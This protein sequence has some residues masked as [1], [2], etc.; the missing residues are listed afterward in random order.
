MYAR[1]I[2]RVVDI[3]L[4][5]IAAVLL[6][7]PMV[8]IGIIIKIDDPKGKVIFKQ[9]RIGRNGKRFK[10]LK[11]RT[12]RSDTPKHLPNNCMTPEEYDEYTTKIGKWL[13]KTS[14]DELPQIYNII[15]GDM[16]WVGPRPVI[17]KEV[18][19]LNARRS[20]GL[21]P[22]RPGLTGWAQINGR[23]KLTDE[24]KADFDAQYVGKISLLFDLVCMWKTLPLVISKSGFTEGCERIDRITDFEE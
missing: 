11:F 7:V 6:M 2:K 18:G 17:E 4:G 21:E 5:L 12:M 14:V 19:L 8:M 13:R 20:A 15:K 23:N 24:E 16:S 3:L 22:F 9:T 10:I 1:Y